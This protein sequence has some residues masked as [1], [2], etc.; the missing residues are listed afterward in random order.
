MSAV[1]FEI[2]GVAASEMSNLDNTSVNFS[3]AG[4]INAEWKGPLTSSGI[5]RFA[6]FSFAFSDASSTPFAVPEMTI[7]PGQFKFA[8]S[9]R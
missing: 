6:P 7:W 4:F 1:T 8:S 2:T 5:A 3:A 9:T